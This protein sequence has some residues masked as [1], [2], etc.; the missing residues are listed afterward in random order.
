M[1]LTEKAVSGCVT[2][3]EAGD[4]KR[5]TILVVDQDVAVHLTVQTFLSND[6]KIIITDSGAEALQYI[7]NEYPDVILCDSQISVSDGASLLSIVK[8]DPKTEKIP[9]IAMSKRADDERS[10]IFDTNADD[11]LVKPFSTKELTARVRLQQKQ[12]LNRALLEESEERFRTLVEKTP[13]PICI[14]KGEDMVLEVANE[15][16]FKVWGVDNTAIGKA[17]LDII[18]EM[19][20]QPFIGLLLDVYK[21]GVTHYG[22]EHPAY[23]IRENGESETIYF[24]FV[25]Q[26]Y[27]EEDGRITGVMVLAT[28]VTEQVT[29]RKKTEDSERHFRLLVKQAPVAICILRG[30]D[31]IVETANDF[32]LKLVEKE[33]DFI[34]KPLFESLP[35]LVSQGFKQLL[36]NVLLTAVAF[37]GNEFEADIP[38]SERKQRGFFNFVYQPMHGA[39][40]TVIGIIVV[41][42]EV[43]ELVLSRKKM[44]VQTHLFEDMLMTAP[45]FVSTLTGPDHVYDLVNEQYQ[46]LFG[47]R[48]IKGKPIMVAL[49]ELEGQ[50]FDTLL[51]KVYQT[52]EPYVGIDIPITLARDENLPPE[53]RYFN[54]SYQ[55]MYDEYKNIYSILVFGYEVTEQMIA[56]KRIEESE[57]RF[58]L[59]TNLM[60]AKITNANADGSVTYSNKNWLDFT[61][62]GF[63]AF[64]NF[65][66]QNIMHPDEIVEFQE[67]FQ[68][69]AETGTD[70]EMEM[71]FRNLDGDYIW[72]LNRASSV[73]DENGAVKMW[74]GVTT[75]IQKLKEEE[76]RKEAFLRMVSHE[77]KTPITS[78][79][80]YV[81]LLLGRLKEEHEKYLLPLPLKSSLIRIDV[82]I[83]RLTKLISEILDLSRLEE[84]KLDLKQELFNLN[85]LVVDTIEDIRYTNLSYTINLVQEIECRIMGDKDRIGQVLINL[86]TN[87]IK[88]SP[89]GKVIDVRIHQA[90]NNQVAISV[91][92]YGIG[93]DK[94]D[95]QKIFERFYRV[96]GQNENNFAGFGIGLFIASEIMKRHH[97][98]ISIDSA[99]GNGS[100]F[101]V[102][103]PQEAM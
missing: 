46:S 87:G 14:L 67:R 22:S 103:L 83:I 45:G 4:L 48:E 77:L 13:Y 91:R 57:H 56:K 85:E 15:A 6:Y 24:N 40:E 55:P 51:D 79:K 68:K 97:G 9:F 90:E 41:A 33:Q 84:G 58:R 53:L 11:Y 89:K 54:F 80:G 21:N 34:G 7:N 70:L 75:E 101:T 43:T 98:G 95:Q 32:Y 59:M 72:H 60:P 23:F 78:I 82:Q 31:H 39:D 30:P 47:K 76:I 49:P 52:G 99:Q 50:G 100:V 29:S 18:P 86:I 44:E 19:K 81:R 20:D 36:D 37:Y 88:Y 28:D 38:R 12:A 71:R 17:F 5:A 10:D 2:N 61:G 96:E 92:D 25:Y 102:T 27:R 3:K 42:T 94:K 74:I 65:G 62:L 66:Y 35:E 64:K 69:A 63:E 26:P 1:E 16:V 73:R 8:Q 93:I